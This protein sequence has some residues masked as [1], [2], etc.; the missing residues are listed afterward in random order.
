MLSTMRGTVS[1]IFAKTLMMFLVVTFAVWGIGDVVRSG[2]SPNTLVTVGDSGITAQEF[3][4]EIQRIQRGAGGTIPPE[5]LNSDGF[6]QEVLKRIVGQRLSEVAAAD[7]GFAMGT[8]LTAKLTRDN[9]M[10]QDEKGR[11]N[12]HAFESYLRETQQTE[13]HYRQMLAKETLYSLYTSSVDFDQLT[14]PASY[15]SLKAIVA[16]EKRNAKLI[17]LSAKSAVK[18][19]DKTLKAYYEQTKDSY[20]QPEKRTI[21]YAVISKASIDKA[22]KGDDS[23]AALEELG[24]TVDDAVAA[25]SSMEKALKDAK[26][27]AHVKSITGTI[28]AGTGDLEQAVIQQG[29]ALE[30]GESSGLLSDKSGTYFMVNVGSVQSASPKPFDVVKA[31]VAKHYQAEKGAELARDKANELKSALNDEKSIDAQ[32]KLAQSKGANV[33]ETGL[34]SRPEG[35]TSKEL[36]ISLVYGLFNADKGDVVG[37]VLLKNGDYALAIL[38]QIEVPQNAPASDKTA[39]AKLNNALAGEIYALWANDA[40]KRYPVTQVGNFPGDAAQE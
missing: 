22:V 3:G 25:G 17:T 1:G 28:D 5:V 27:D 7:S 18:A 19:D 37:P 11:F 34:L 29:F 4:R 9:P 40:V 13:A 8:D 14:L 2:A 31:D 33:R 35:N 21:H 24:Y 38:S 15:I 10:F 20:L 39:T 32:V 23:G 30:E 6:R 16:A 12:A 26:L 36:P